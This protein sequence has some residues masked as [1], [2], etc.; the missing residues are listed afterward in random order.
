MILIP[1]R[2][3][4]YVK[5]TQVTRQA[6]T[7][8]TFR[9]EQGHKIVP[10]EV[11]EEAEEA[12]VEVEVDEEEEEA[13]DDVRTLEEPTPHNNA[14]PESVIYPMHKSHELVIV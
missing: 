1:I 12:Q 11:E 9:Q 5:L 7:S 14:T 6:R 13:E 2:L 8:N 10:V 3:V 4:R